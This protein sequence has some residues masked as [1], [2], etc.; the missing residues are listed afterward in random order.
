MLWRRSGAPA[1][2]T[3]QLPCAHEEAAWTTPNTMSSAFHACPTGDMDGTSEQT[4]DLD[5]P[6]PPAIFESPIV[7]Q[8]VC[9]AHI[10]QLTVMRHVMRH[11]G[12]CRP[13]VDNAGHDAIAGARRWRVR[14]HA[15]RF[16]GVP[17]ER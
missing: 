14:S 6:T 15:R 7:V 2:S 11:R 12:F 17:P 5:R 8:C 4:H 13:V 9:H 10:G 3:S 1:S 16:C